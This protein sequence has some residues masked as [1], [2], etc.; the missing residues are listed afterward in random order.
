MGVLVCSLARVFITAPTFPA[1]ITAARA[2][3]RRAVDGV[4]RVFRGDPVAPSPS[5]GSV[6][7]A[8]DAV[9][10]P[11]RRGRLAASVLLHLAAWGLGALEI[12]IALTCIGVDSVSFT[13]VVVIE[14]LSQAAVPDQLMIA[15]LK[16][17]KLA[18]KDEIVKIED[19]ILPD[20]IA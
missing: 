6:Y 11:G 2:I 4:R 7:D 13:E 8:L 9:W 17:K 20:I 3:G 1:P 18:I 15:R 14:A 12:W 10:A 5:G 16:R 19:V